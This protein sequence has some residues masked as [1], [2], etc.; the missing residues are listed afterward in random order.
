MDI[1]V[2]DIRVLAGSRRRYIA[3]R[4]TRTGSVFQRALLDG[5]PLQGDIAVMECR[6]ELVSWARTEWWNGYP[7]LEAFT[8]PEYRRIGYATACAAALVAFRADLQGETLA[9][10]RPQMAELARRLGLRHKLF[11]RQPDGSWK[12]VQP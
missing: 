11:E 12:V 9:V 2:Q 8:L 7:T 3:D 6:S 4:L 10:F 1:F 5:S